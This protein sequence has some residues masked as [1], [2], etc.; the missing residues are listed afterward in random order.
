MVVLF[1]F[2]LG[3]FIFLFYYNEGYSSTVKNDKVERIISETIKIIRGGD[4]NFD[5]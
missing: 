1:Y 2:S 4:F 3:Y 5:Y